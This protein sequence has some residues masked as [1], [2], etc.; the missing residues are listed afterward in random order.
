MKYLKIVIVEIKGHCPVYRQG[1]VFYLREGYILDTQ[2]SCSVCMHGLVSLLPY[3]TALSR[4]VSPKDLG[5][6]PDKEQ[7]A[8]VQ[9]LDPCEYTGGGTVIFEIAEVE[10]DENDPIG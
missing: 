2:K 8:R 6:S 1:D 4:G 5:L 9:C 3:Y 10:T 7:P